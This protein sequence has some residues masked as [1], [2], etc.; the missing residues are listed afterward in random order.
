VQRIV[1]TRTRRAVGG[2]WQRNGHLWQNGTRKG[3]AFQDA[4]GSLEISLSI[5]AR[6][7]GHIGLIDH[8]HFGRR[9]RDDGFTSCRE[10]GNRHG[11][12]SD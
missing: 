10:Y 9:W 7:A 8:C 12:Y 11:D 5:A 2:I 1:H 6:T 3:H 4:R